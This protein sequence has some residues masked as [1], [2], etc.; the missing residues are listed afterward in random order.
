LGAPLPAAQVKPPIGVQFLTCRHAWLVVLRRRQASRGVGKEI[1]LPK[2]KVKE[3]V[4]VLREAGGHLLLFGAALSG[5]PDGLEIA[6]PLGKPLE[7]LLGG[8]LCMLG[9]E[10][11]AGVLDGLIGT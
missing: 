8:Y 10:R 4:P 7:Q 9:D 1:L 2:G 6:S 5:D 3:P 11:V